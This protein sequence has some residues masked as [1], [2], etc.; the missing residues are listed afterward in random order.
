MIFKFKLI[1]TLSLGLMFMVAACSDDST[2]PDL[3]EPP[4]L[5]ADLTPAEVDLS[6]FENQNVPNDEDHSFYNSVEQAAYMG[7]GA[8]QAGGMFT[9][10]HS[11]LTFAQFTGVQPELDGDTWIWTISI[12]QDMFKTVEGLGT[13]SQ[14]NNDQ[15]TIRIYATPRSNGV[16]WE[17]RFTGYLEG[18]DFVDNFRLMTGFTSDDSMQGEWNIFLPETG[19]TPMISY[20]WEKESETVFELYITAYDNGNVLTVDY[21]RNGAENWLTFSDGAQGVSTYWN[22]DT[23]SGWIEDETGLRCH[24][25][26]FVNVGC[27]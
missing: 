1:F 26:N 10:A 9:V 8:F 13:L 7:A 4:S 27:S 5:P 25:E 24:Y 2:S 11:F 20:N 6:Y 16:D 14:A 12:S 23:D 19:S 15:I 18:D 21:E 3:D 22:T 17:I